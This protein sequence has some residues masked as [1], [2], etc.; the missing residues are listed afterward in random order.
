MIS[1]VDTETPNTGPGLVKQ[2]EHIFS[3]SGPLS[4]S[5]N[6]EYRPQQQQMAVAVANA[7][8]NGTHLA[9]EAG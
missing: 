1:I 6:F 4:K 8:E 2:V 7:L 5:A 3:T 9:A